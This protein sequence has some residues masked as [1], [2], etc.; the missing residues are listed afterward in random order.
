MVDAILI[1]RI[2][3]YLAA[4]FMGVLALAIWVLCLFSSTALNAFIPIEAFYYLYPPARTSSRFFGALLIMA[5][6]NV[7]WVNDEFG[8]FTTKFGRGGF[9]AMYPS[10]L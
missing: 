7:E 2:M 1:T 5:D 9:C 6:F 10:A 8:F 3:T 4:V